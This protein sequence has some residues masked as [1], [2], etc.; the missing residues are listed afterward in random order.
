VN[1]HAYDYPITID[2][3]AAA[4]VDDQ[5]FSLTGTVDMTQTLVDSAQGASTE[6]VHSYGILSRVNGVK[7]RVGR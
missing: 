5:N 7:H 2:Y 3:S 6:N 1:R 4:Y